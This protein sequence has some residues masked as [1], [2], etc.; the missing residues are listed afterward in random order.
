MTVEEIGKAIMA[1]TDP[2]ERN[3]LLDRYRAMSATPAVVEWVE[4]EE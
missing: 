1:E 2:T 4:D 3:K